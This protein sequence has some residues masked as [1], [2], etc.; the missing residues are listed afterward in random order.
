MTMKL[1]LVRHGKA[2]EADEFEGTDELRPLTEEGFRQF[3]KEV[4]GL[5][6]MVPKLSAIWR[7][8]LLRARQTADL[9]AEGYPGIKISEFAELAPTVD[10][11]RIV[12]LIQSSSFKD[13]ALVGHEPHLSSLAS[14]LLS[15]NS[16]SF[17]VLK[18]G[19]AVCLEFETRV[20]PKKAFL[21]WHL[22][23]NQIRRLSEALGD[24]S[25]AD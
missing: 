5:S 21:N 18:K 22:E 9:L 16:R 10:P 7:S 19:G 15:G 1:V 6:L 11:A 12:S 17:V 25:E 3:K 8:P 13:L 24:R 2:I 23:P 14:Y 20:A 4:R